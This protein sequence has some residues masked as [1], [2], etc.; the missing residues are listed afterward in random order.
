MGYKNINPRIID[1]DNFINECGLFTSNTD[2]NNGYGCKSKSKDKCE[3]GKCYSWD[4]PL[5]VEADEQAFKDVD[6]NLYI[7]FKKGLLT[8]GEWLLQYREIVKKNSLTARKEVSNGKHN[9][10]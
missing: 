5:A 1:I 2:L 10:L 7:D 6:S 4:C 9:T 3:K 8:E